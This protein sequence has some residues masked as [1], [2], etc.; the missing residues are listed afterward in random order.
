MPHQ[1][2]LNLD[3]RMPRLPASI[4]PMLARVV[5]EPFDSS[6]H[7]FE[8][9]WGG[10]RALA[11]LEPDPEGR[12]ALTQLLDEHGRDLAGLFPELAAIAGLLAAESAVLD[13]EIVVVD[14]L[15]R[16]DRPSL[17]SRLR[18]E[19]GPG[20]AF[21]AFDA[22]Y[23][24]GR[25]LLGEPLERRR[26]AL[27][28]LLRAGDEAIAVPSIAGEGRALH[29]AVEAAGIAAVM[30]RVRRSP[31]LPGVRSRL[32]TL[33]PRK[34]Q[35]VEARGDVEAGAEAHGQPRREPGRSPVLALIRRLPLDDVD[36]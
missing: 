34:G 27:R 23:R 33:V 20:V 4:R 26:E 18:G 3:V 17:E 30:A 16:G 36:A 1:L 25:P 29:D 22:L 2:S 21:L 11:F 35:N 6:E 7:L 9:S 10:L 14:R 8:P 31:Y 19:P 13:G 15:G 28:R 24:D 32:W 12:T 5:S